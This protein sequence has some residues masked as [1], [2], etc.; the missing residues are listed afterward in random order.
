MSEQ[1]IDDAAAAKED[2]VERDPRA[3]LIVAKRACTP[4]QRRWF[5]ELPGHDMQEWSAATALGISHHTVHRWKR[6]PRVKRV[7][8]L[9]HEIDIADADI[10]R[11]RVVKNWEAMAKSD[12]RLFFRKKGEGH[13]FELIPPCEWTDEMAAMVEELSFDSSG[14]PRIKLTGRKQVSDTLAK[15]NGMLVERHEVTGKDG[16]PLNATPPVIQI[17]QRADPD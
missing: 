17:V 4:K 12:M 7:L 3:E 14:N 1:T 16:L 5:K 15:Y 8:E 2:A 6:D 10:G 11:R 9:M 13:P